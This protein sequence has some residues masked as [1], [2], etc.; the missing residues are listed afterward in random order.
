MVEIL[1]IGLYRCVTWF[2]ILGG[3]DILGVYEIRD[4]KQIFGQTSD[5]QEQEI[6]SLITFTIRN[7]RE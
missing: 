6:Y 7:R 1:P 2:I 4:R 5:Q 3:K